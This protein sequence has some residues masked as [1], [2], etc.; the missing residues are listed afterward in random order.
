MPRVIS[1]DVL[2]MSCTKEIL[3][4]KLCELPEKFIL[5]PK[6]FPLDLIFDKP[7]D[8]KCSLL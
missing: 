1:D 8:L 7:S 4:Y 5:W 6:A 2:H 3:S